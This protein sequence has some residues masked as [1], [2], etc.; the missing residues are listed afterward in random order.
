MS[1]DSRPGEQR[2][3][4]G[5][6]G[7]A[8]GTEPG[9]VP[10]SD[11]GSDSGRDPGGD[12]RRAG[13]DT[14]AVPGR[15]DRAAEDTPDDRTPDGPDLLELDERS[16]RLLL[17]DVV[18]DVEP[19]P[20]ALDRIHRAVP[21]RRARRRQLAVGAVAAGLVAGFAVPV[22]TQSGVVSRVLDGTST[23][24]ADDT[25]R[26]GG[27]AT[28]DHGGDSDRVE[29]GGDLR[30]GEETA[31]APGGEGSPGD[32]RPAEPGTDDTLAPVSPACL[33]SQLDD[34]GTGAEP[35]D[36]DGQV[37]GV[38]RITNVS[39]SSCRITGPDTVS[40]TV[41]GGTGDGDVTVVHHTGGS[42]ATRLPDPGPAPDSV[43]LAPGRS[44]EVRFA[45]VPDE[46][47]APGCLPSSDPSPA[48]SSGTGGGAGTGDGS[49][50]G[51]TDGDGGDGG[52]TGET[53]DGTSTGTSTGAGGGDGTEGGD[54][55]P[56]ESPGGT[57]TNAATPQLG[58]D[59]G[60]PG[61]GTAASPTVLLRYVPAAGE[62]RIGRV[63]IATACAGTVY[64]TGPLQAK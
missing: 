15:D 57:G 24:A 30:D 10:G 63:E 53:G 2:E 13:D 3:P 16:L 32:G 7:P 58:Y 45:W 52:T 21:A 11:S 46:G 33:R 25:R 37:Y 27:S 22:L 42:R 4:H 23:S 41:L 64:R 36:A 62:P 40:A 9:T 14:P 6:H 51:G 19:S 17:R 55:L 44:Y 20:D 49:G 61:G 26:D 43:V 12:R 38:F 5:A 8:P 28:D 48:P 35:A 31:G 34:G 54:A 1:G 29:A 39:D 47:G 50:T 56:E 60:G 59:T 18:Q